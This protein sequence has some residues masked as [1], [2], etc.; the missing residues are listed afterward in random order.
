MTDTIRAVA[1]AVCHDGRGRIL[2]ERGYD[3]VSGE[4]FLRA[5]G[6]GVEFGERAVDA[7][8][9]EW[10]EELGLEL[11]SP[12]L[13][14]VI[15]NLFTSEGRAGH[16]VVFVFSAR[17]ADAAVYAREALVATES[18]GSRHEALWVPLDELRRG[19]TPFKPAGLLDLVPSP[20]I[21]IPPDGDRALSHTRSILGIV[22]GVLMIASS[23]AHSLLGWPSLRASLAQAGAPDDLAQGLA[24]G[25]HW[26]GAAMV[27]FA[28]IVLWTFLRRLQG[29]AVSLVPPGIVSALYL[30]FGAAAIAITGDAFFLVFIVPGLLLAIASFPR[31]VSES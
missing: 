16:E 11:E 29:D 13:L 20:P 23:A 22:A 3:R 17:L 14:G 4:H 9:R 10:R 25:W 5:I 24:V 18:D 1:L 6:G 31:R 7:L 27:A 30:A 12:A 2:V 28:C 15:E 26:G 21:P 19:P 8:A